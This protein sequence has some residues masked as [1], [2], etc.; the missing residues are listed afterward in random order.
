M[1]RVFAAW[2]RNRR[3]RVEGCSEM[4]TIVSDDDHESALSPRWS[5]IRVEACTPSLGF[6]G[7]RGSRRAADEPPE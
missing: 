4:R 6:R 1:L 2:K 3:A 7:E 5:L